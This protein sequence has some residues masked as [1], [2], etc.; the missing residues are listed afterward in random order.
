MYSYTQRLSR[1]D[2]P[3]FYSGRSRN[4]TPVKQRSFRKGFTTDCTQD[5]FSQ[6]TKAVGYC[7]EKATNISDAKEMLREAYSKMNGISNSLNAKEANLKRIGRQLNTSSKVQEN[8]ES[9]S[10]DLRTRKLQALNSMV[11]D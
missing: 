4:T 11:V 7:Q 8:I 2:S 9:R 1:K 6:Y 3:S 5:Q 10:N